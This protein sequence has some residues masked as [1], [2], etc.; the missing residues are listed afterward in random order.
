MLYDRCVSMGNGAGRSF[1]ARAVGPIRTQR[2]RAAALAAL[3]KPDLRSFQEDT[4]GL[5]PDGTWS[6]LTHAA[7]VDA[8][9]DL[10]D[11]SPVEIPSLDE[12]L[13]RMVAAA[14]GRRFEVRLRALRTSDDLRDTRYQVL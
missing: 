3:E 8:L 6:P 1:V 7:L 13:D 5:T 12:M 14:A 4:P 11:D 9:R 2:Q 10:G